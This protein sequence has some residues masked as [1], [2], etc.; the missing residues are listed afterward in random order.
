M[1]KSILFVLL[2]SLLLNACNSVGEIEA[3]EA[4]ARPAMTGSNDAVYFL[5]HNH[6]LQDDELVSAS[7]NVAEAVE[8]HKSMAGADDTMQMVMQPSVPLPAGAELEFAPGGLHIM[9]I[10]LK[11]DLRAG[12]QFVVTLHF[13]NY[14]DIVLQ[15]HVQE[16]A[17]MNMDHSAP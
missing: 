16:N 3:H 10:G 2:A 11:Q 7:S 12:D 9:L 15:V 6:T 1:R 5:L 4:W 8:L 17:G 14:K 13:K